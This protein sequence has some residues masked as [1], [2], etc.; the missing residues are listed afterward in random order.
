L[1]IACC[2]THLWRFRFIQ[3]ITQCHH[4]KGVDTF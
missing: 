1:G 2:V 3:L 4:A